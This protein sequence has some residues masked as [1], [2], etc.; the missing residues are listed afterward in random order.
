[1]GMRP[2]VTQQLFEKIP[3]IKER[4]LKKGTGI[5]PAFRINTTCKLGCS[6]KIQAEAFP[7]LIFQREKGITRHHIPMIG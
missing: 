1:M 7:L 2:Y 3:S 4:I 6:T 5:D